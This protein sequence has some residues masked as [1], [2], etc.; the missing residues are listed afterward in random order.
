M[1]SLKDRPY[2][3]VVA[4]DASAIVYGR[5]TMRSPLWKI[6]SLRNDTARRKT[7]ELISDRGGRAF[8][9]HG[10]GRHTMGNE[11]GPKEHASEAFARDIADRIRKAMHSGNCRGYALI[12]AP[13]FLGRLADAVERNV[14]EAPFLTIDKS[15][16][17]HDREF[18]E[19][20][21]ADHL[22]K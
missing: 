6:T 10:P 8:D 1:Q 19:Q 13:R 22:E 2:W 15:V 20:L 3:I 14:N 7:A 12:A 4:D 18:I 5:E 16:V 21:I 11:A 17:A 9:S